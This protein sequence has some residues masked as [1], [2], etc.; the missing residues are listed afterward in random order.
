MRNLGIFSLY[1]AHALCLWGLVVSLIASLKKDLR[2]LESAKRSLFLIFVLNLISVAS[3]IVA[4]VRDD[5][6]IKYVFEYSRK[7][8]PLIYKITALWGGMDGSLLLWEFILSFYCVVAIFF[9]R[10]KIYNLLSSSSFIFFLLQGFFLFLL[11]FKTNPFSLLID[12]DG[13]AVNMALLPLI[14]GN[15]LNPLLQNVYMAV[16]PPLLYLGFVGFAIPFSLI[17]SVLW[18]KEKRTLYL[19]SVR[20]WIFYSWLSLGIGILFGSYWAYIELGGGGYWAWD[21]DENASLIPWL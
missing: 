6:T 9:L 2:Y 17:L 20:D 21:P 13:N 4:F 1:L 11:T 16:H 7:A 3:L 14:D 12:A 19:L 5:F 10:R 8:Q 15:G 18:E